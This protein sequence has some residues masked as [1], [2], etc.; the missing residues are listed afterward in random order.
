MRKLYNLP[1]TDPRFLAMTT[2]QIELEYQH[3]LLDN[4]ELAK[5]E[6]YSDPDYDNW[7]QKAIKE[8]ARISVNEKGSAEKMRRTNEKEAIESHSN[9]EWEEVELDADL[10]TERS[11]D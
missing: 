1:P 10:T 9:D 5:D 3:F 8:D 11:E 6:K 4:P 7:E 2:E